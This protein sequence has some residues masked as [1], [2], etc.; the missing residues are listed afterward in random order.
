MSPA[1][2]GT[3]QWYQVIFRDV[4]APDGTFIGRDVVK[5]LA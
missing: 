1:M 4:N 5:L 2:V 3:S